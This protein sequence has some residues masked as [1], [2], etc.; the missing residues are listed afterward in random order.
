MDDG[1]A[2]GLPHMKQAEELQTTVS[3]FLVPLTVTAPDSQDF[4]AV[5]ESAGSTRLSAG[6]VRSTPHRVR[7]EARSMSSSDPD[8]F[9][10][11]LHRR[12]SAW[13]SQGGRQRQVR[14]G[15][16]LAL[17]TTR[18]YTLSLPDPCDVVVV[19]LPRGL[20]GPHAKTL[21]RRSGE[22]VPSDAG[23]GALCAALLTG[24][25]DQVDSLGPS[26]TEYVLDAVTGLLIGAL[27]DVPAE[28]V[29]TPAAAIVDRIVAFTL[30]NLHDPDL[31]AAS[32]AARHGISPRWLHQLF[33]GREHTFTAWVRHERLKRIHRDLTNPALA[34][35]TVAAVAADWGLLDPTHLAR[36]LRDEFGCTAAELR[37]SAQPER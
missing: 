11:T 8:L 15:D 34:H 25:G 37:R 19:G 30:A 31:C 21:A 4:R 17:D 36:A 16:L 20:L 27:A 2:A 1:H 22:P 10:V 18:P 14:T 29:E 3:S 35:R 28:R 5:V 26:H 12:G 13:A 24:L 32:V 6:R 7:R 9:K 33:R 23:M